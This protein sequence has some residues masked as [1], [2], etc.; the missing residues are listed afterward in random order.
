MS[1]IQPL[2]LL[3]RVEQKINDRLSPTAKGIVMALLSYALFVTVGALVRMLNSRIDVFQILLF[4][5]VLFVI[6][7]LPAIKGAWPQMV[8]PRLIRL[9]LIRIIGAFASLYFGYV[10]VSNLPLADATALGFTNVLFVAV[11]ARVFLGE[12]V[13]LSR[14][15]TIGLGFAGVMLII[16]PEF[17]D[18][19]A[20][21]I[22]VGLGAA[23]GAAIAASCVRRMSQS[24][25]RAVLLAYQAIF[26]GLI[27][28]IPALLNWQWP[29]VNEMALLVLV[30]VISA[31]A[32][33]LGVSAYKF[34]EANIIAN[35]SYCQLFYS[36]LLGYW[37]FSEVPD[38]QAVLG[39]ALLIVSAFMPLFK[40]R[41]VN[42]LHHS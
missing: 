11:I 8:R 5:Q 20:G 13:G 21:Y 24:E 6:L 7:L 4:R 34:V 22:L 9:H 42:Y 18:P 40:R 36:M 3:S 25:P 30:G 31:L 41:L 28:F 17:D 37:L 32:T 35:V 1:Q 29:T 38:Q 10:A 19:S 27:A 12:N 26:V 16:R 14:V 23:M 15:I 2:P 33:W 39:V